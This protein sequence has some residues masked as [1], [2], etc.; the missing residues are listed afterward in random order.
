MIEDWEIGMLYLNCMKNGDE[1][2]AIEK[3]KQRYFN[4]FVNRD[5]YFYLGTTLEHHNT[6]R[7]PFIVIGV[8][9]PP[10]PPEHEQLSMF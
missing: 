4:D 8:F 7:N 3:V 1:A 6:S 9:Y 2:A 5:I 10:M